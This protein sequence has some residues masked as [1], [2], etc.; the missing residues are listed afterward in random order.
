MDKA[1]FVPKENHAE[2]LVDGARE[3]ANKAFKLRITISRT[4]TEQISVGL[5]TPC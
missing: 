5:D 2:T 4:N 3:L 1:L